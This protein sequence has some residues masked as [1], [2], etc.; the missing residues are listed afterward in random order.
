MLT[1]LTN[2]A[3]NRGVYVKVCVVESGSTGKSCIIKTNKYP[4]HWPIAQLTRTNIVNE[5]AA[6]SDSKRFQILFGGRF[7][8]Q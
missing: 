8:A 3:S 7:S 2:T 5:Q 6:V 1:G 4:A